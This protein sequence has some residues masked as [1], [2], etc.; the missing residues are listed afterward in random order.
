MTSETSLPLIPLAVGVVCLLVAVL[1]RPDRRRLPPGPKGLPILGNI[2]DAPKE[3]EWR[4]F[5]EWGRIY[6]SDVVHFQILGT[7]YMILNSA[8]ATTELF[9]KRSNLYSDKPEAAMLH[10]TGWDRN[11]GLM[12]YGDFW[13]AHRKI[14]HQHFR[15]NVVSAYHQRTE[16][17]VHQLLRLLYAEPECF[18]EHIHFM[19]AYNII[20]IV[21]GVDINSEGDP[22]LAIVE[23]ALD[24]LRNF[25]NPGVYLVDSFPLLRFIPSWFPGAKFK[26]DAEAWKP[27]VDKMYMQPYSDLKTAYEKGV[28]RPCLG[29]KM[30]AELYKDGANFQSE[31]LEQVIINTTGTVNAAA[32]DTS[33]SVLLVFILAMLLYPEVQ[34]AAQTELDQVIGTDRLPVI[35]DEE[36][37]PY[38]TALV[39]E[40]L[41]WRPVLPIGNAHKSSAD[42]EY[43][44]YHIPAGTVIF[45]NARAILH[46]DKQF[47]N[48]DAFDPNRFLD[49][50]GRLLE[51]L[52]NTISSAFGF[53]RRMCPGRY[54]ALD[55]IWLTAANVL[56]A[57]TIEKPFDEMGNVVEP[58]GEFIS[59]LVSH[60]APFKAVFKPRSTIAFAL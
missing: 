28:P 39:R 40:T 11:W 27:V 19:T 48:P 8:K 57:F 29:T 54:F 22:T 31:I 18:I 15:S 20:G 1:N 5:Q 56:A 7:H 16:N 58:S 32:S 9:E 17:A 42:D 46:D 44:G 41:R 52:A 14:F 38:I 23:E 37:L 47:P 55:V 33:R 4:T 60:P 59:G 12:K 24:I 25:G 10:L 26:R 6:D 3:H 45:G 30:L 36:S 53:G 35:E 49:S 34:L 51:H 21:Y 43:E 2:F 50:N 13:R